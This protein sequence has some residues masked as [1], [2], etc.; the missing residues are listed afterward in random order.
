M[1]LTRAIFISPDK[2]KTVYYHGGTGRP[3]VFLHGGGVDASC[4][5]KLLELL[6]ERY[7]VIAPNLAGH[8]GS[9]SPAAAWEWN[10]YAA[11]ITDLLRHL[12]VTGVVVVGHSFGGGVA[13]HLVAA[14]ATVS[15]LVLIDSAGTPLRWTLGSMLNLMFAQ[16]VVNSF[17]Y[18]APGVTLRLIS[19]ALANLV[20]KGTHTPATLLSMRRL[21]T[22]TDDVFGNISIPTLILWGKLDKVFPNKSAEQIRSQISNATVQ[23]IDGDHEWCLYQPQVAAEKIIDWVG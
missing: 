17:N 11:P 22:S 2:F 18:C 3:L 20:R 9:S 8:G 14:G 16:R 4:Y 21:L 5:H 10:N 15:K 1:K 13:A 19:S 12:N 23:I 6:A 7:M